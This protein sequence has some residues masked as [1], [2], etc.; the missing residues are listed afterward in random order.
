MLELRIKTR[1][2]SHHELPGLPFPFSPASRSHILH[3]C[4]ALSAHSSFILLPLNTPSLFLLSLCVLNSAILQGL[5]QLPDTS[6]NFPQ[7]SILFHCS[8]LWKILVKSLWHSSP[9]ISSCG[10]SHLPRKFRKTNKQT[11]LNYEMKIAT[12]SKLSLYILFGWEVYHWLKWW[13]RALWTILVREGRFWVKRPP[14]QWVSHY[15]NLVWASPIF[16]GGNLEIL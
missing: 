7:P 14:W 3:C 9:S 10:M 8:Y 12:N 2:W 13:L 1:L 15:G 6:K 5:G 11:L 4:L 16:I